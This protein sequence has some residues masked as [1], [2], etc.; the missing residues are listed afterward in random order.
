MLFVN[1]HSVLY[2]STFKVLLAS[3]FVKFITALKPIVD[4]FITILRALK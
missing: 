1:A 2:R 4:L 3:G